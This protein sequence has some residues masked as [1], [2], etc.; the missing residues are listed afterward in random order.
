MAE[1][2][3]KKNDTNNIEPET[4]KNIE[5]SIQNLIIEFS[6]ELKK[7]NGDKIQIERS[8]TLEIKEKDLRIAYNNTG[9][10]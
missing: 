10:K 2:L 9:A 5:E 7:I 3:E 6:K 1:L 4:I 8:I